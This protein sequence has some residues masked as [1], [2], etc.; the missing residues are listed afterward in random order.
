[1]GR[2]QDKVAIVTGG[3][4]GLG[5]ACAEI[6]AMEGAKSF[7][8]TSTEPRANGPPQPFAAWWPSISNMTSLKRTTGAASCRNARIDTAVSTYW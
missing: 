6:F 3:A 7:S 8:P 4:V 2:V 5:Q 1:M